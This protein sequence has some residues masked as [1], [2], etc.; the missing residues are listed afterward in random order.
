MTRSPGSA[1]R[2][3]RAIVILAGAAA[4]CSRAPARQDFSASSVLTVGIG[5][6]PSSSPQEGVQQ[7]VQLLSREALVRFTEDGRPRAG[8]VKEWTV[9]PDSLSVSLTLRNGLTF[10]DGTTVSADDIVNSVKTSL[11]RT[12]GPA[13][14]DVELIASRRP[15]EI[16]FTFNR[17]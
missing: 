4:G 16:D 11:P 10:Y 13:F 3:A 5:P 15:G 7:L 12:M 8:L 14:D 17:P 2:L 6:L 9:S 1:H